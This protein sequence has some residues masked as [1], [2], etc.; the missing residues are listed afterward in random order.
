MYLPLLAA[1]LPEDWRV[2]EEATFSSPSGTDIHLRLNRARNEWNSS[3][4]AAQMEAAARI[5]VRGIKEI[6]ASTM[7]LTGGRVAHDRRF[8]SES[9]G[10]ASI[11]RVVCLVED[12]LAL[13]VSASWTEGGLGAD[14]DIDI[15]VA[16]IRLLN[17]PVT[18]APAASDMPPARAPAKRP[19]VD[20]SAWSE[21]R[22][23]W[24][25]THPVE[26]RLRRV[27]RWSPV[28]LSV[29]AAVLGAPSFP[30]V[31]GELLASMSPDGLIATLDAVTRSLLAR[32]L[33]RAGDDGLTDLSED[34]RELMEVALY[35]D[36]TI[37]VER[38]GAP[39][40]GRWWFGLRPDRAA[41][42]TVLPDGSRECAEIEPDHVIAQLLALTQAPGIVAADPTG[43]ADA[44]RVTLQ[45]LVDGTG[46]VLALVRFNSTWRVGETVRGGTFTWAIGAD[47]AL[48][49]AEPQAKE[50][51]PVWQLRSI[52][53][54]GLR[55][56]LLA[57]LPG[58]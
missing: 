22:N 39:A 26:A 41:Q 25:G 6:T 4:L 17:R 57:H 14:A 52:D 12:G 15:A 3:D 37:L 50:A 28:E 18:D 7:P 33:V 23:A 34:L 38:L 42:V 53:F 20:S 9:D 43:P 55:S 48:W 44:G 47:G 32:G 19:P 40:N 58:T 46:P 27:T 16:S 5:Q 29:C 8:T 35:A 45:D 49:L 31:G 10:I 1:D 24:S 36:L 51:T 13:T 21:L 11:G 56:D 2:S 30:T 54:E